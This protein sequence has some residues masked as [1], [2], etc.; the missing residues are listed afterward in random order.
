M[1]QPR[2]KLPP[3]VYDTIELMALAF[4]GIGGGRDFLFNPNSGETCPWCV[5][6]LAR[7]SDPAADF[8]S[9]VALILETFL[10]RCDNDE[11][12]A[13]INN[14]LGRDPGVRVTFKRWAKQLNVVRGD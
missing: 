13:A 12:V 3:D 5:Y 10:G 14:R 7:A 1:R 8:N 6:G 4:G 2:R 11:A 9:K